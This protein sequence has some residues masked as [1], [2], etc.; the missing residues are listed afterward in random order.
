MRLLLD[1]HV[2]LALI[3]RGTAD[4]PA[5][6][7]AL[8]QDPENEHHLSAASLWETAIKWRLGK[9]KLTP[10]LTSLPE[11]LIGLGIKII[12]INEHHA[13]ASPEPEP[14]TRDPFD[15]MLLAQCQVENLKLVTMDR[16]LLDHPLV[17]PTPRR[18]P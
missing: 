12:A 4:L 17:A 15:R 7:A 13:L 6:V 11:L 8:L 5:N 10:S 2:L 1:T 14:V 3:E 18:V 9:L 16:A